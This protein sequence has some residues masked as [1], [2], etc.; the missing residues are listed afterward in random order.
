MQIKVQLR[1]SLGVQY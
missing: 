1:A